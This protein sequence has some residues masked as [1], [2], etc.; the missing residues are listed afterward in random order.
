MMAMDAAAG[1][2]AGDALHLACAL[3]AKA[4]GIVTLDTI[5]AKNA[6]RFKLKLVA[7]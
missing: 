6:T 1:L 5:L 3:E 4:Q 7:I 2:R